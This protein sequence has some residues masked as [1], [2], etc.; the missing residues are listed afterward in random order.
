MRCTWLSPL[1][2]GVTVGLDLLPVVGALAPPPQQ[3][4]LSQVL[5]GELAI[6]HA[7][8]LSVHLLYV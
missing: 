5:A 6:V 1:K 4:D 8:V 2:S 3:L 7:I